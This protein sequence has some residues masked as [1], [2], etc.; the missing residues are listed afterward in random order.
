[1]MVRIP[2]KA[3]LLFFLA[4]ADILIRRESFA[5]IEL[6][7]EVVGH[8]ESIQVRF[9]MVMGL[10]VI[11]F[12]GGV[13]ERAVHAFSLAIR[14]G[15]IGFGQPMVDALLLADATKDMLKGILI[16]LPVGELDAIIGQ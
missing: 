4:S 2:D 15:M 6:L 5:C 1:M 3:F 10:I 11:L 12:H 16:A 14:P 13:F 8:Q 9:Q 7:G